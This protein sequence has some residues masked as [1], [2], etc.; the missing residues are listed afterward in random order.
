[1]DNIN[2]RKESKSW[3]WDFFLA[4]KLSRC[5]ASSRVMSSCGGRFFL[6]ESGSTHRYIKILKRIEPISDQW[7]PQGQPAND[8]YIMILNHGQW[9]LWRETD[10][11]TLASD[12]PQP[13][14][15]KLWSGWLEAKMAHIFFCLSKR[16]RF[17]ETS[18]VL[19]IFLVH[20]SQILIESQ[21][22]FSSPELR[23]QRNPWMLFWSVAGA[24]C[25]QIDCKGTFWLRWEE[26]GHLRFL[27]DWFIPNIACSKKNQDD[28]H[29]HAFCWNN[30]GTRIP[31][32]KGN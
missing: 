23:R 31:F 15:L 25:C 16:K 11:V 17:W 32:P 14:A 27:W 9:L 21:P 28:L 19:V 1:M 12:L 7:S 6:V 8:T 24:V 20:H 4:G 2:R 5:P 18:H 10:M 26:S 3:F 30:Y 13:Q 22:L 29:T